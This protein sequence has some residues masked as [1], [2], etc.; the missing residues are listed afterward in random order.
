MPEK[1]SYGF[2][3]RNDVRF[4]DSMATVRAKETLPFDE[5]RCS[6][7]RLRTQKGTVA[8]I[9]NIRIEYIFS[10]NKL[11]EVVWKLEDGSD[12]ITTDA[13]ACAY[14]KL[15]RAYA[16]KYGNPLWLKR[17]QHHRITTEAV[18]AKTGRPPMEYDEWIVDLGENEHVKID[19]SLTY[20]LTYVQG[21]I[22]H[23]NPHI[24]I[25]TP[26]LSWEIRIGY[27]HFTEAD[28]NIARMQK[29]PRSFTL[30]NDI[31]FGDSMATVRAKETLPFKEDECTQECLWT[32][33]GTVA[34]VGGIHLRYMFTDGKLQEIE[35]QLDEYPAFSVEAYDEAY[36]QLYK[37][38]EDNYGSALGYKHG[39]CHPVTTHIIDSAVYLWKHVN[40]ADDG[41][42]YNPSSIECLKN[43]RRYDEWVVH[44]GQNEHVKLDLVQLYCAIGNHSTRWRFVF[45]GYKYFTEMEWDAAIQ[46]KKT[47]NQAVF[48]DI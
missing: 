9:A 8:G 27:K 30:R 45:V 44:F 48:N 4:G 23:S 24:P 28:S 46:Q 1:S 5:E 42:F 7:E 6:Q 13:Y 21:L 31:H 26:H 34:G 19:L 18:S 22:L 38:L 14:Q 25:G 16:E 29:A 35:W 17:G 41:H 2:T 12:D 15:H 37:M 33:K 43:M 20:G 47:E 39:R 32:Q 11:Q 36:A 10:A 40:E 3:L